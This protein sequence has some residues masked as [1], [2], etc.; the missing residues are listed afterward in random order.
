[1]I[2]RTPA[3]SQI[4]VIIPSLT[5]ARFGFTGECLI[6]LAA[7]SWSSSKNF[8]ST[9]STCTQHSQQHMFHCFMKNTHIHAHSRHRSQMSTFCLINVSGRSTYSSVHCRW[10]SV[11]CCSHSSVEQSSIARH[12]CPPS[13]SSAVVL[14]HI[15]SHFLIPLFGSSLIRTVPAQWLAILDNNIIAIR[16]NIFTARCTIVQVCKA[17]S[18]DRMSSSCLSFCDVGGLWSH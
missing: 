16:C 6:Q 10:Q 17:R 9:S 11:S 14:N 2:S 7:F 12:C 4:T 8:L 3:N 1:M 18:C 15:S 13:P 5:L